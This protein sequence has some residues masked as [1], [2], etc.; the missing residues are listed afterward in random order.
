MP[1]K[2]RTLYVKI[3]DD[4]KVH[5]APDGTCLLYIDRQLVLEVTS[6]GSFSA[7]KTIS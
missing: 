6:G 3:W 4:H 5:K 1:E 7:C 2:P